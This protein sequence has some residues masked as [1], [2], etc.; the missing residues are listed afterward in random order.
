MSLRLY[1]YCPSSR[2]IITISNPNRVRQE[3]V[4]I[5]VKSKQ[6]LASGMMSLS[7]DEETLDIDFQASA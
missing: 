7:I 1:A 3:I 6:G 2:E 4:F 5:Q